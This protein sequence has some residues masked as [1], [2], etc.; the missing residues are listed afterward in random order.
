[1]L[2][3]EYFLN[4]IATLKLNVSNNIVEEPCIAVCHSEN[5]EF[6]ALHVCIHLIIIVI[7]ASDS[8]GMMIHIKNLA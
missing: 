8:C 6:H 4:L 7:I 3:V 5:R 1:M 2:S